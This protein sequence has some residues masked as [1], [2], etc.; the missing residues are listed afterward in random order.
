MRTYRFV[1]TVSIG[2]S[3]VIAFGMTLWNW[4]ENPGGIFHDTSGTSWSFVSDTF[5]SWFWP[6]LLLLLPVFLLAAYLKGPVGH[7]PR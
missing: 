7:G 6:L 2:I 3:I 1:L 5:F 4:I